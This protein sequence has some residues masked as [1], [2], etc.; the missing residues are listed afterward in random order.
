[1]ANRTALVWQPAEWR[2]GASQVLPAYRRTDYPW[3]LVELRAA[4]LLV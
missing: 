3:P 2:L 1:M 4:S